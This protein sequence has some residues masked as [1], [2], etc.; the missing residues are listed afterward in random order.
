[1]LDT[2]NT[3]QWSEEEN[4]WK[5]TKR[6][7]T[8]AS[9]F[10]KTIAGFTYFG[11]LGIS[12]G[13]IATSLSTT[14][15]GAMDAIPLHPIEPSEMF[16]PDSVVGGEE[17]TIF[18]ADKTTTTPPPPKTKLARVPWGGFDS[19]VNPDHPFFGPKEV[20][21]KAPANEV[22]V[23]EAVDTQVYH[24][25]AFDPHEVE[26]LRPED[27]LEGGSHAYVQEVDNPTFDQMVDEA[28]EW[29]TSVITSPDNNFTSTPNG[30]RAG[31][32]NINRQPNVYNGELDIQSSP[33]EVYIS[34]RQSR[35]TRGHD[36]V[37]VREATTRPTRSAV[38]Y[39]HLQFKDVTHVVDTADDNNFTPVF[40]GPEQFDT[41]VYEVHS[42]T[43]NDSAW[44]M[45]FIGKKVYMKY[46][47]RPMKVTRRNIYTAEDLAGKSFKFVPPRSLTVAWLKMRKE[48]PKETNSYMR[49]PKHKGSTKPKPITP[50]KVP[51]HHEHFVPSGIAVHKSHKMQLRHTKHKKKCIKKRRGKCIKYA[52]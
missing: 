20:V 42:A 23:T 33:D 3:F 2:D 44:D 26:P 27:P 50:A 7:E 10:T 35:A 4:R 52:I 25:P 31:R 14:N 37:Y 9:W 5:N 19:N 34:S 46:G 51:K 15:V 39:K 49:I 11:G 48:F 12:S 6:P 16:H 45:G 29:D 1:M 18:S 41:T 22:V 17:E 43:A 32:P 13:E 8:W 47:G 40:G 21:A 24:N 28:T 30:P 38:P 36:L